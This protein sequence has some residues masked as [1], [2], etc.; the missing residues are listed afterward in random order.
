MKLFH[1]PHSRSTRARWLLEELGVPCE[2]YRLDFATHENHSE[3][4]LRIHPLGQVPALLEEEGPVFESAAICLHLADRW[5]QAGLAPA[6]GTHQR[7]LYYQWMLFGASTLDP[8]LVDLFAHQKFHADDP[9]WAA[10]AAT[11]RERA[12]RQLA[13]V[14]R[15]LEGQDYLLG[16]FSAADVVMGSLVHLAEGLRLLEGFPNLQAYAARLKSRPAWQRATSD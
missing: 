12:P 6:P 16:A 15:A 8:T 9:V 3:S 4:Y 14:E 7:G 2:V 1:V 5:P 13:V 10:R 11:A